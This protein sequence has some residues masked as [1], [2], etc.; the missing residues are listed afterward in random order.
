MHYIIENGATLFAGALS[1]IDKAF[2]AGVQNLLVGKNQTI[3]TNKTGISN[4]IK[5]KYLK[6]VV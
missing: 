4:E 2:V 5:E 3:Q 1:S 6:V